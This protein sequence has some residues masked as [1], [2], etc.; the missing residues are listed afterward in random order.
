VRDTSD[1]PP[2]ILDELPNLPRNADRKA[3]A[4]IITRLLF[5]VS[6]RSLEIWPLKWRRVNGHSLAATEDALKFAWRKFAAA[7]VMKGGRRFMLADDCE[8]AA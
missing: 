5:P 4:D 3:L 8:T 2:Y 1:L 7:P 6:D